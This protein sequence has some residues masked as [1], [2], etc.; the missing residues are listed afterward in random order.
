MPAVRVIA[1][2]IICLLLTW[3]C[4]VP[5]Y[6]IQV[7]TW[8]QDA[9]PPTLKAVRG[10]DL[11]LRSNWSLSPGLLLTV[12]VWSS[13]L[14]SF[15]G[16]G[17]LISNRCLAALIAGS[18]SL[19]LSISYIFYLGV[20]SLIVGAVFVLAI[21]VEE[22]HWGYGIPMWVLAHVLLIGVSWLGTCSIDKTNPSSLT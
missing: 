2:V 17:C 9:P 20:C 16:V 19:L 8:A 10:L 15:V 18:I 14:S 22:F 6:Q 12:L 1:G 5:A 13:L 4:A 7:S 11:A 3:A 21:S